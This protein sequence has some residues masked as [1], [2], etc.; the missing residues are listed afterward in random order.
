M[1]NQILKDINN[2]NI[3]G[4]AA[5]ARSGLRYI[6]ETILSTQT[7]NTSILHKKVR[8]ASKNVLS[9][10]QTEPL[11]YNLIHYLFLEPPTGSVTLYK[12][13]LLHRVNLLIQKLDNHSS[14]ITNISLAKISFPCTIYT[15]CHSNTVDQI[16]VAAKNKG[17]RF[18]VNITETRPTFQGRKTAT[19]LAKV[20]IPVSYYI[21]SA[22]RLAIKGADLVILGCDS[23]T[24]TQ[25]INKIGSGIICHLAHDL[26]IPVYIITHAL[27]YD[28]RSRYGRDTPIEYRNNKEVWDN[29]PLGVTIHNPVFEPIHPE[30][31]TG[32]ISELGILPHNAF[33]TEVRKEYPWIEHTFH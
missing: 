8:L 26:D 19:S 9:L 14:Y 21:D 33:I 13:Y 29:P 12:R 5:I 17:K 7:Q 11:L 31:V 16:L 24:Q 2:L 6:K 30:L 28:P 18:L 15:H 3:Q 10:R 22:A 4:A 25:I 20:H 23:I 27:K 1:Q 32:I